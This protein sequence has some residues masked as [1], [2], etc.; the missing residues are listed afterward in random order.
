MDKSVTPDKNGEGKEQEVVEVEK[1]KEKEEIV[2]QHLKQ[3]RLIKAGVPKGAVLNSLIS[4]GVEVD[5]A[6]DIFKQLMDIKQRRA[7]E[8]KGNQ[9]KN[10][11]IRVIGSLSR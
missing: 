5:E 6:T 4:D 1:N 11:Q 9:S 7:E 10:L 8:T 3:Y 2:S